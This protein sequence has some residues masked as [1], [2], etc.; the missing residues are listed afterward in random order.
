M[1]RG[2]AIVLLLGVRLALLARS[3]R[4]ALNGGF[5]AMSRAAQRLK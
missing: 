3:Q 4:H 2:S 5:R 1:S